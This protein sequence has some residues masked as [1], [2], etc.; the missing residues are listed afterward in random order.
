VSV[1]VVVPHPEQVP[2]SR[3]SSGKGCAGCAKLLSITVSSKSFR[4][5]G[6]GEVVLPRGRFFYPIVLI[7]EHCL[8]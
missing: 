3:V 8:Y 5:P 4:G 7:V 1:L 6:L 2:R